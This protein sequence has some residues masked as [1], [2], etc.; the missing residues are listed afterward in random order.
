MGGL[1]R[2]SI[3]GLRIAIARF[4]ESI[5]P[6]GKLAFFEIDV[7]NRD[8]H[9]LSHSEIAGAKRISQHLSGQLRNAA[10]SQ[11]LTKYPL[12]PATGLSE[13]G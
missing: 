2:K 13:P 6:T 11:G 8:Y 5:E 10:N 7:E 9:Q 4:S 12:R 3:I 1:R